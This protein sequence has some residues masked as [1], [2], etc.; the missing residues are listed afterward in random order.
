M[1]VTENLFWN[2]LKTCILGK[3]TV[4]QI[5]C[6][7]IVALYITCGTYVNNTCSNYMR[8]LLE[9]HKVVTGFSFVIFN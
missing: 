2:I 7:I 6:D 3:N 4:T 9:N 8:D 1:N 5:A